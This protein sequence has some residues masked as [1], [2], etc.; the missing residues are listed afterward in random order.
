MTNHST[1]FGNL[2]SIESRASDLSWWFIENTLLLNPTKT[3]AVIFS[4]SQTMSQVNKSQGVHVAGAH[5]QFADDIKLLGVMLDSTL[6][7]NKHV[8]EITCHCHHHICALRNIRP[9]WKYDAAKAM[10]VSIVGSRLAYIVTVFHT[11]CRRLTLIGYSMFKK[12]PNTSRCKGT[13]DY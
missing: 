13:V 9:L 1:D 10:A 7:F 3:E 8:V 5:V 12:C 4:T 2:S 6:Y 11:A